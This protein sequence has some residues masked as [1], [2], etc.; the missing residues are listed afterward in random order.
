MVHH[1]VRGGAALV[2]DI[3]SVL[4]GTIGVPTSSLRVC[5]SYMAGSNVPENEKKFATQRHG[6]SKK[7]K[8]RKK[9]KARKKATRIYYTIE[10]I[11]GKNT[12]AYVVHLTKAV[13]IQCLSP[14]IVFAQC[15]LFQ[16]N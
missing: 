4:L 10:L 9:K 8:K 6:M 16:L 2:K 5:L 11:C 1:R 13:P 14:N 3:Q 12:A 7:K 15:Q